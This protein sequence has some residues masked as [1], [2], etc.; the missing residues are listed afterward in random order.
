[1]IIFHD[2]TEVLLETP[3][4]KKSQFFENFIIDIFLIFFRFFMKNLVDVRP[5]AG[6]AS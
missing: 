1:M 6:Q 5:K 4:T 2:F 3:E